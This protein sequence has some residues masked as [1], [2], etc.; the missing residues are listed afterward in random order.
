MTG[1]IGG[2]LQSAALTTEFQMSARD[3]DKDGVREMPWWR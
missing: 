2:A 1:D 3:V